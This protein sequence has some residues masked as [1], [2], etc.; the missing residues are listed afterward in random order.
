MQEPIVESDTDVDNNSAA[1]QAV[2]DQV[3]AATCGEIRG[4]EVDCDGQVLTIRGEVDDWDVW[5]LVFHAVWV[6]AKA[7][8]GL[9]FDVQVHVVT[10]S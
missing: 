6:E 1:I 4:L 2:I 8:E 10:R 9:L 7:G 5:W 3:Q